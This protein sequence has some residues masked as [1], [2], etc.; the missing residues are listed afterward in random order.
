M[1]LKDLSNES[2]QGIP[3]SKWRATGMSYSEVANSNNFN[4]AQLTSFR[5][6][7]HFVNSIS[8]FLIPGKCKVSWDL[9]SLGGL[10]GGWLQLSP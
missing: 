4:S 8:D 6:I 3:W 9:C 10:E 7:S 2:S 5:K 1:K